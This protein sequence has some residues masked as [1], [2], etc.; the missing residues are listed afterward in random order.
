MDGQTTLQT[1]YLEK[2]DEYDEMIAKDDNRDDGRYQLTEAE[3]NVFFEAIQKFQQEKGS[4]ATWMQIRQEM[5]KKNYPDIEGL[6]EKKGHPFVKAA[7]YWTDKV[8][9]TPCL[10]YVSMEKWNDD[11]QTFTERF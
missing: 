3:L 2:K 9:M 4:P 5:A 11:Y 6:D 1:P 10:N 8:F 7:I